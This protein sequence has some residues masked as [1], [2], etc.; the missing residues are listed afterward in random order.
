M[1]AGIAL[2]RKYPH[3][4][5]VEAILELRVQCEADVQ[6]GSAVGMIEPGDNVSSVQNVNGEFT[7]TPGQGVPEVGSDVLGYTIAKA[8]STHFAFVR[9]DGFTF[10]QRGHYDGWEGFERAADSTWARY[11][12]A[13]RPVIVSGASVRFVNHIPLPPPPVEISDYLRTTVQVSAYLPQSVSDLFMQVE[14]PFFDVGTT[15]RITSAMI[16]TEVGP[17]LLLDID[18]RSDVTLEP[19]SSSF[20][21]QLR[22]TLTALRNTKNYVFEACITDATRGLIG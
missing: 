5:I 17:A 20:D 6:V 11:K 16:G 9:P 21:E 2:G 14:V 7:A 3:A 10:A 13:F 15:A 1:P 19:R 12:S 4:P 22:A 8:D 18:V